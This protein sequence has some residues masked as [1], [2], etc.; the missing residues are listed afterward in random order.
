MD[1]APRVLMSIAIEPAEFTFFPDIDRLPEDSHRLW[2][3]SAAPSYFLARAWL[4]CLIAGALDRGDQVALG[5]LQSRAGRVLALLPARFTAGGLGPVHGRK[6]RSLT[7]PYAC[8][9][10]PV[11]APDVDSIQAARSLGR[12]L[13][14]SVARSDI[15]HLDAVDQAWAE[16][17]AFEAGLREAGFAIAQYDHFGNWSEAVAGRSFEQY[18][19]GREGSIREIVRRRRRTLE[20]Q[21]AHCEVHSESAGIEAAIATYETVYSRSWKQPEPYPQFHEHL[22]RAAAREGALRLGFCYRGDRPIAVQLWICWAGC[23]TVLKLAHDQE[24]DRFSPGTVLLA[25]MIRH[26]IEEDG[27]KEIDF[28]R[29]DD[30]YKRQWATLRR[31]RI[32]LIVANPRSIIGLGVLAK[33]FVGRWLS[34]LRRAT[35]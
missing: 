23:A 10:R 17:G 29:G 30:A 34:S 4:E 35:P 26:V 32:G 16:L 13:G 27:A 15:I 11:L 21:G 1:R 33:Q 5:V 7:G 28:G 8:L 18:L 20:K 6:L 9:F 31:Q 24:F 25:H 22:M 12:H 3:G 14:S 19:A 2:S